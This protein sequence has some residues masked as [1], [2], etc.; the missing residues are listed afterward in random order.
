MEILLYSRKLVEKRQKHQRRRLYAPN[1]HWERWLYSGGDGNESQ[2]ARGH[3]A[4]M[5]ARR[6][7]TPNDS[8]AEDEA[9]DTDT[10]DA[11]SRRLEEARG[12][13]RRRQRSAGGSPIST[14]SQRNNSPDE[15]VPSTRSLR[16]RGLLADAIEWMQHSE[17]L[18][19]AFKLTIAALLVTWPGL[20]P[21]LNNFYSSNRGSTNV[22]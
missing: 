14:S 4:K 8:G 15:E 1:I 17:D 11:L 6:S 16:I 18:L 9:D 21:S 10:P 22:L 2:F 13:R 19:Y 3:N 20:V 5:E 12:L 7:P